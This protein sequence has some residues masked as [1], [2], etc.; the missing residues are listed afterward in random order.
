M[1]LVKFRS[2]P[3]APLAVPPSDDDV[4]PSF[5]QFKV[6]EFGVIEMVTEDEKPQLEC[7]E[8]LDGPAVFSDTMARLT[9]TSDRRAA[10]RPPSAPDADDGPSHSAT[11]S[12]AFTS[13]Q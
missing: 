8:K 13:T 9:A 11:Q 3:A 10:G 7:D 2:E 6:N 1:R 4:S 12:A 5:V